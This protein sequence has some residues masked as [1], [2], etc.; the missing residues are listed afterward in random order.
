MQGPRHT[1]GA[2]INIALHTL[3]SLARAA[4]LLAG[5]TERTESHVEN[6]R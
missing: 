2:E 1:Q 6:T 4:Q 3:L 5:S